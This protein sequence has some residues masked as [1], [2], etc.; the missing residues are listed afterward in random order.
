M[1]V[2]YNKNVRKNLNYTIKNITYPNSIITWISPN[3]IGNYENQAFVNYKLLTKNGILFRLWDG[4]LPPNLTLSANGI[5]SG[6]INDEVTSFNEYKFKI[7]A[8]NDHYFSEKDF[9]IRVIKVDHVPIWITDIIDPVGEMSDVNVQFVA[10]GATEYTTNSYCPLGLTMNTSGELYGTLSKDIATN[11][12]YDLTIVATNSIGSS[13]KTFTLN[14]IDL[15]PNW[16]SKDAG[17][18]KQL[19]TVYEQLNATNTNSFQLIDGRLPDGLTFNQRGIIAGTMITNSPGNYDLSVRALNANG[20]RDKIL[21]LKVDNL[22]IWITDSDLGSVNESQEIHIQLEAFGAN[23]FSITDLLPEGILLSSDGVISGK[24]LQDIT[25]DVILNFNVNATNSSGAS[26]KQFTLKITDSYP[27]WFDP[28]PNVAANEINKPIDLSII[29]IIGYF[30]RFSTIT[31]QLYATNVST[32]ILQSGNLP[33][34]L[35][36]DSLGFIFGTMTENITSDTMYNFTVRALNSKGYRDRNFSIG[37]TL[38]PIWV[39]DEYLGKF[40]ENDSI[41]IQFEAN[42]AVSFRADS[43]LPTGLT[44]SS[45]GLLSGTM[46]DIQYD[47]SYKFTIIAYAE[48]FDPNGNRYFSSKDFI[49]DVIDIYPNW[50][51]TNNLIGNF[52]GLSRVSY[53]LLAT[54]AN[55]FTLQSGNLPDGL[56]L[57]SFGRIS[58]ILTTIETVSPAIYNF[59]VRA[60]NDNGYRDHDFIMKIISIIYPKEVFDYPVWEMN[61]NLGTF[62]ERSYVDVQIVAENASS[63]ELR[64]DS[65]LPAGL[66][67]NSVGQIYGTLT[68]DVSTDA[69]YYFSITAHNSSSF[70]SENFSL[71]V[72]DKF[73]NWIESGRIGFPEEY[74]VINDT[75]NPPQTFTQI[76]LDYIFNELG[77]V[78]YTLVASNYSMFSLQNPLPNDLV[79]ENKV[80]SGDLNDTILSE[81]TYNFVIRA[82]N[83]NGDTD[84]HFSIT[85]QPFLPEWSSPQDLGSTYVL[86][87]INLKLVA[88]NADAYTLQSGILPSGMVLI[89]DGTLSGTLTETL[90]VDTIYNFTVRAMNAHHYTDRD[91]TVRL[92][93]LIPEWV[94]NYN[95]GPV[96]EKSEVNIQLHASFTRYY[97]LD[98]STIFPNFLDMN[99][100][101]LITGILDDYLTEDKIYNFIVNARNT[102]ALVSRQFSLKVLNVYPVWDDATINSND[103]LT[104][105]LGNFDEL[106]NVNY[107]LTVKNANSFSLQNDSSLPNG[108]TLNSS[109]N[110]SGTLKTEISGDT[111]YIFTIRAFGVVGYR[112]CI[113]TLT[114]N[115]IYP[116]WGSNKFLGYFNKGSDVNCPLDVSNATSFSLIVGGL[117]SGLTLN[118]TTG[119]I[120]GTL[121]DRH[122]A[123]NETSLFIIRASN[124]N[125]FRDCRLSM[126]VVYIYPVFSNNLNLG[127]YEDKDALN[128]QI[129]ASNATK[130][131]SSNLPHWLTLS[132]NGV[133]TVPTNGIFD[134]TT[135]PDITTTTT[136]TFNIKASNDISFTDQ[137]FTITILY[138]YWLTD[139]FLGEFDSFSSVNIQLQVTDTTSFSL[140]SGSFPEGIAIGS[141]GLISGTMIVG[142]EN[143]T[144]YNITVRAH[145]IHEYKDKNFYMIVNSTYMPKWITPEGNLGSYNECDTVDIKLEIRHFTALE[146]SLPTY[147]SIDNTGHITGTLPELSSNYIFDFTVKASSPYGYINRSFSMTILDI[148]PNWL[149]SD[150]III[151]NEFDTI[152]YQLEATNTTGFN[153]QSGNFPSG[154]TLNSN[155]VILGTLTDKI[156]SNTNYNFTVRASNSYGNRDQTLTITVK[157]KYPTWV[158]TGSIGTFDDYSTLNYQLNAPDTQTFSLYSG[159]FPAGI[160]VSS[161]GIISGTITDEVFSNTTYNFTIRATNSY[162]NVDKDLSLIVKGLPPSWQTDSNLGTFIELSNVNIQVYA[163]TTSAYSLV[164]GSNYPPGLTMNTSGVIS[165]TLNSVTTNTTFSFTLRASSNLGYADQT[166]SLTVND[167]YIDW[168]T[169]GSIGNFNELTAVSYQLNATPNATYSFIDGTFPSSISLSSSGRISGTLTEEL[170]SNST[171]NFT[172]RA[173]NSYGY[174]DQNLNMTVVATKPVWSGNS[175]LGTYNELFT[176]DG[177]QLHASNTLLYTVSNGNFP[178]GLTLSDDGVIYG[179]LSEVTVDTTYSFTITA[180]NDLG[181]TN[182]TFSLT[183][184]DRIPTWASV[185]LLGPYQ[186]EDVISEQLPVSYSHGAYTTTVVDGSLPLGLTLNSAHKLVGTLPIGSANNYTFTIHA[187]SPNGSN[188]SDQSI[189]ITVNQRINVLLMHFDGNF[190]DVYKHTVSK[191]GNVAISSNNS[192][193]GGTSLYC[194][195]TGGYLEVAS[196]KD[197][198]FPSG[199]D[200]TIELWMWFSD[201]NTSYCFLSNNWGVLRW[202]SIQNSLTMYNDYT[203]GGNETSFNFIPSIHSWDFYSF[204]RIGSVLYFHCNGIFKSSIAFPGNPYIN[205]GDF[206]HSPSTLLIGSEDRRSNGGGGQIVY[207][208]KG[209]IDELKISKHVGK[210]GNSD[211]DPPTEPFTE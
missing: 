28:T 148:Y 193:F 80:I 124:A 78:N 151:C 19:A 122:L 40:N 74:K 181:N 54:N 126:T 73:P 82:T 188:S 113:C 18:F 173:T 83:E 121:I 187:E 69:T 136:Y 161:D 120:V 107:Q 131:T 177:I 37:I 31:E 41:N 93:T 132:L 71:S 11:T 58:G 127:T 144:R 184:I 46:N 114:V 207:P 169:S 85:V 171:Y 63:Y 12:S 175:N 141:T 35:S 94:T 26:T 208:F 146:Y 118:S 123:D 111:L 42:D 79:L 22:P 206:G 103:T 211:Y 203:V 159:N 36:F 7:R 77:S 70:S 174:K 50:R 205:G 194:P 76:R 87:D 158:T 30:N 209:Y 67:I 29:K 162:G 3:L 155:G 13:E 182:K 176:I 198:A 6:I 128:I 163:R 72:V 143:Q 195:G 168:I 104:K 2:I 200:F 25:E 96:N 68:E 53:L 95:I 152:N 201:I 147:L 137:D 49:M 75:V 48:S 61:T 100:D 102:H 190:N 133:L 10:V 8:S 166:F 105:F 129:N 117:P 135:V 116:N 167:K 64:E 154:L 60:S 92:I 140:Q 38:K 150:V 178:N 185:V 33:Q 62:D 59:T 84:G 99:S 157:D 39:T 24:L 138:L 34:G 180:H 9:I 56:T 108:L 20:Y 21:T 15:Y 153:I 88:N 43:A 112:D 179:T 57:N 32:F 165:G 90:S 4:N 139:E 44:I 65:S 91:F 204:S 66:T 134:I 156:T 16:I 52:E 191:S 81:T 101:G 192:K 210:Y 109:G 196:S 47:S 98:G 97:E 119:V 199:M 106:S 27:N 172:I 186:E 45:S 125:G 130:Y 1:A 115:D 160:T 86:S 55:L 142:V 170:W 14:I 197:F 5:I 23:F 89:S 189:S 164:S 110:I 17:Y 51:Y 145:G 149:S 183:V 202:K